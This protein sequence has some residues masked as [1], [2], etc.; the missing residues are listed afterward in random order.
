MAYN[1]G[2]NVVEVDGT[3]A[4]AIVG[5]STSVGAFNILTMRGVPNWPSLVTSFRQFTDQFGAYF[6]GGYGA[7]MVKGFFDNGG[8]FAYI[9]RVVATDPTTGAAGAAIS[10]AD[11]GNKNTLGLTSGF[12]GMQD[13]GAWANDAYVAVKGGSAPSSRLLETAL[14]FIQSDPL[15]PPINMG[16]LPSLTVQVDGESAATVINFVNGDFAN[17]AA[18]TLPEIRDAINQRT[19]KLVA[20]I[21]NDSR[22]VLTSTGQVA[23]LRKDWTSLKIG[24]AN[25]TLGFGA[26]PAQATLGTIAALAAGS[27]RVANSDAFQVADAVLISDG[28]RSAIVKILR[29]GSDSRAI[30]WTPVLANNP[31]PGDFTLASTTLTPVEFDLVI[32][33]GGTDDRSV[34]ETWAGLSMES[35]VPNYAPKVLNDSAL[36]SRYLTATDLHSTSGV[37]LTPPKK[38]DPTRLNPGRNGT[39]TATD[40]I[41]DPSAHTGFYAFDPSDVQL[42]CCERTDPT[43]VTAG[44]G[45]CAGRGDCMYV[46]AVPQASVA[47]KQAKAYGQAFQGK[48]VYGALYGP[49]VKVVD[50]IG[51]GATPVKFI[52]PVGHV[53]GIYA[54]VETSRGIWKAPAGDEANIVGALDVEYQLSDA[55]HTDLVK[56]GSVNGIRAIAGAGVVVDASRTLSTDTRWLYVNVRLLFNYVKSSLKHGLRW[57]R[58]EPNRD[59][60][61]TAVKFSSVRPFL[62]E[63]WR[64]GAFGTGKPEQVFTIICDATNNPPSEVDQGNF[65]LEVYFYPSKPA[66][67]IIILVGQ[68]RSGAT[69]SEA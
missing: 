21:S 36:G 8:Q 4:P 13:P 43:I 9:N 63:L 67:T 61:W 5:A 57:V 60:L 3:G 47:A 41:G 52:P 25:A 65:K 7:Y 35:D 50:P 27:G 14:A 39:P 37:G 66:E 15:V 33:K 17:P 45:Y 34:V 53:M 49:W 62:M 46:G 1:I 16:A 2:L 11:G 42:V 44:L 55:E 10:L 20:S 28:T 69:A 29:I 68:Q 48:K 19:T 51:T 32:Y 30:E 6:T 18:A 23:R 56:S 26:V 24:V 38:M 59:T 12:R 64:Q 58:Q 40:F 22:L 54:R 31:A